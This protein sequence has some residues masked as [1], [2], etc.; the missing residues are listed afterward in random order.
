M[1]IQSG[2]LYT[3]TVCVKSLVISLIQSGD[4][5]CPF[6]LYSHFRLHFLYY[7]L[8]V[9]W[10]IWRFLQRSLITTTASSTCNLEIA[11]WP[12]T[13]PQQLKANVVLSQIIHQYNP[14]LQ[15]KRM[16]TINSLIKLSSYKP[17]VVWNQPPPSHYY[18]CTVE[19]L[20]TVYGCLH[21]ESF[22]KPS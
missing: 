7:V 21:S 11:K 16:N 12:L 20:D 10:F 22:K 4:L 13:L 2:Y 5:C 6:Y 3:T 19:V 8:S 1:H 18:H 15:T 9:H 17:G 14:L